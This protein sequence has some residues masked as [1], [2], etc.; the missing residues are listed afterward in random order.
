MSGSSNSFW[1]R[2]KR[3]GYG[4][5]WPIAWQGWALLGSYVAVLYICKLMID[6]D[7]DV[8][9]ISALAIGVPAT[10]AVFYISARKTRGGW[11]WRWGDEE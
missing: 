2:P 1:F 11:H 8:G 10:A 5:G 7:R 4:A 3:Y 9:A 6:W